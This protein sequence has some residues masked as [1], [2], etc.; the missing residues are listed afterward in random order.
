MDMKPSYN[1]LLGRPSIHMAGAIPSTLHQ[2]VK[3]MVDEQLT[4]SYIDMNES[5][6]ECSFQS[7]EVV[8]ATFVGIGQKVSTPQ[9]SKI[10]KRGIKQTVGKVA[11]ARFGLGKFLQ[12]SLKALLVIMKYDRYGLGYKPNAKN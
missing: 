11:G 5:V 2:K 9:L 4:N 3:F 8:N 12:G 6:I 7:L 10:T 1:C